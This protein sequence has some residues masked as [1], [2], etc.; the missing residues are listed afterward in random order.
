MSIHNI[1]IAETKK[2]I[3]KEK[4]KIEGIS[5]RRQALGA[6]LLDV[7]AMKYNNDAQFLRAQRK[8]KRQ[9]NFQ[10]KKTAMAEGAVAFV[11]IS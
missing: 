11:V 9:S 7:R 5:A 10:A 2:N 3:E 6:R 8:A 4:R 1:G